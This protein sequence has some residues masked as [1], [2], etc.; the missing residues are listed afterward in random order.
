[1]DNHKPSHTPEPWRFGKWTARPEADWQVFCDAL[2]VTPCPSVTL[3]ADAARIVACVNACAG[4]ADPAAIPNALEAL[5]R[6]DA[7]GWLDSV[8]C[9]PLAGFVRAALAALGG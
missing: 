8:P 2:E 4:I 3:E 9:G 7:S 1:M 5:R 6:V